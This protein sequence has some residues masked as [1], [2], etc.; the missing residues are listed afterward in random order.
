MKKRFLRIALTSTLLIVALLATLVLW[1]SE[2]LSS[3]P[4]RGV[5]PYQEAWLSTPEKQGIRY[6]E[7]TSPIGKFPYF[8]IEPAGSTPAKRGQTLREELS[9]R[10]LSVPQYGTTQQHLILLHGRKGSKEDLLPIAERYVA[11]GFRCLIPD[12]PG[13]GSNPLDRSYF[14]TNP[15]NQEALLSM[16]LTEETATNFTKKPALLGMSM[17][18]SF[19]CQLAGA[20]SE[21]F[22]KVLIINSF[23]ELDNVINHKCETYLPGIGELIATPVK[24]CSDK[25]W[26]FDIATANSV[27][28]LQNCPLPLLVAHGDEDNF[29]P[30]TLG[31]RLYD[32]APN[33]D[34]KWINVKGAHH[35]NVLVTAH[36]LYADTVEFLWKQ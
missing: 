21:A 18:G 13:H 5:Q 26:G 22:S 27:L 29:I 17:G 11:A 23:D 33:T 2:D 3:P 24:F 6:R 35:T 12:L 30:Q 9:E 14:G 36:P 34:K 1:A 8:I 20:N 19:A 32:S 31:K 15:E 10:K 16:V 25:I 28:A 4:R 7:A